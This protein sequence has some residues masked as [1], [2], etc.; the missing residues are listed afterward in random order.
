MCVGRRERRGDGGE[1]D[2]GGRVEEVRGRFNGM[3]GGARK[4]GCGLGKNSIDVR[5]S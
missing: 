1:E 3:E 5:R 2:K 4:R